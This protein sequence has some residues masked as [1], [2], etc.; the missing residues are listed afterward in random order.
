MISAVSEICHWPS[1]ATPLSFANHFQD[2]LF[3]TSEMLNSII[4]STHVGLMD[5]C[6]D[7][8]SDMAGFLLLGRP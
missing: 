1:L 6:L 8:S 2:K 5:A 3:E 4:A 7:Y